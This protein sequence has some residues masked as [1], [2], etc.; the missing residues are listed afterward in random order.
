MLNHGTPI[1]TYQR[2]R[3]VG[4]PPVSAAVDAATQA[5]GEA[6]RLADAGYKLTP[7]TITRAPNGKKKA[8]FHKGWRHESAWSSDPEQIR[9]WWVDHQGTTS[10]AIGCAV[11]GIEGVDLDVKPDQDVDAVTWWAR[12]GLPISSFEQRTPSGGAHLIWRVRDDGLAL[13]QEAG[14]SLGTGVD[15]RNR[16]GLFFAA[17]GYV[18][19]EPGHYEIVGSLP[20]LAQLDETPREV[21]ELFAEHATADRAERPTDGRIVVHD[22]DWQR[23]QVDLALQAIREHSRNAGGYRA[24]LQHAGLFL[25]RVV[26]QGLISPERAEGWIVDAHK[27]VWGP[28]VWP[29]NLKD[30]RDALRDG[31]VLERWRTPADPGPRNGA[32]LKPATPLYAMPTLP[33]GD[34]P[35][36]EGADEEVDDEPAAAVEGMGD[37]E[38]AQ[39]LEFRKDVAYEKRRERIRRQAREELEAERRPPAPAIRDGLISFAQ[40]AEIEPPAMLVRRLIP[41]RAVGFLNGRSGSY[42]S[43]V[44]VALA[45]GM[46]TGRPI[47]GHPEFEVARPV[48][49]LYVAAEGSA[50]VALRM[51]AYAHH[52]GITDAPNLTLY[53]RAINLTSEREVEDLAQVVANGG[54]E[55]VLVDTFRQATLGVNESDNS[56]LSVVIGRM[57][58]LRDDHGTSTLFADHTGHAGE[59]AVGGEAKWA[60]SDFALMIKMPNGNRAADQQRTLT[61]EKLKDLDT[62]GAWDLRLT[63]VPAIADA[64]GNP[65]AVVELGTAAPALDPFGQIHPRWWEQDIEVPPVVV[66]LTDAGSDAAREIYRVLWYTEDEMT[67]AALQR[68]INERPG[69]KQYSEPTVRRGRRLLEGA[70]VIGMGSGATKYV[71]LDPYAPPDRG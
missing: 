28:A 40:L 29:E 18:V 46:A 42:K 31:P 41:E 43:F 37:E 44:L 2:P 12:Q 64:D 34:E 57:I 70:R 14:K 6:T 24:K 10:F 9:A 19:D 47:L 61:V 56:E 51:R 66:G 36:D 50:G 52:H 13:P 22:E 20:P 71:L 63:A 69:G 38:A 21:V 5:L 39:Y 32:G 59:R 58:A 27:E 55:H 35:A 45:V 11:N 16:A 25:G 1:S 8:Q 30:V 15:T 26:E 7:V 3:R 62:S 60:N 65:S 33:D 4:I 67:T 49:V 68:A 53:P 54:Y 17:G 23:A 48:K